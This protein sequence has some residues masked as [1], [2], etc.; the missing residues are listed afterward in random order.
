MN[1]RSLGLALM[2]LALGF[3]SAAAGEETPHEQ[4]LKKMLG[5]L[6]ELT[7]TLSKVTD[8]DTAQAERGNLRKAAKAWTEIKTKQ[9]ELPPPDKAEKDR[10]AKEYKGKLETALTKFFTE[11]GRVRGFPAGKDVL[12]EIKAVAKP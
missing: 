2:G 6:D 3:L 11:V 12:D 5:T 10:L 8:A 4:S 1:V 9:A 7:K